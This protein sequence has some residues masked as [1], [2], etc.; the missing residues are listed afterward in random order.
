MPLATARS[1]LQ[2]WPRAACLSCSFFFSPF[3]CQLGSSGFSFV[4]FAAFVQLLGLFF[5]SRTSPAECKGTLCLLSCREN[6]GLQLWQSGQIDLELCDHGDSNLE[7]QEPQHTS[8]WTCRGKEH[9]NTVF[10]C[11]FSAFETGSFCC[12][13]RSSTVRSS[14]TSSLF[15]VTITARLIVSFDRGYFTCGYPSWPVLGC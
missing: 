14:I 12:L 10:C 13:L 3:S 7:A 9:Y 2:K 4:V 1:W 5:S 8:Q 11:I 15:F 6:L